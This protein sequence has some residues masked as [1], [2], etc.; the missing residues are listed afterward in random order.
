MRYRISHTHSCGFISFQHTRK[1][2]LEI[3]SLAT[4]LTMLVFLACLA[5]HGWS[6]WCFQFSSCILNR[7]L[8]LLVLK[9]YEQIPRDLLAL[10]SFGFSI[11]HFYFSLNLAFVANTL[12]SFGHK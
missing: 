9:V 2:R 3:I 8:E 5:R 11:G 12:Q 7:F 6:H 4:G 1:F 10:S